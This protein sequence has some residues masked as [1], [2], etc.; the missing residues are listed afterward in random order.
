[1]ITVCAAFSALG[2]GL[3][4]L[5]F[6]ETS[7]LYSIKFKKHMHINRERIKKSWKKFMKG[8]LENVGTFQGSLNFDSSRI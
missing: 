1:M 2:P 3:T 8:T 4:Y 7:R 5:S 6:S